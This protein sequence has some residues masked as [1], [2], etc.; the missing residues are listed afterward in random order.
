MR[1]VSTSG[2]GSQS[3]YLF[4]G[5]LNTGKYSVKQFGGAMKHT[6]PN[7]VM[8]PPYGADFVILPTQGFG[9][10]E[11][12]KAALVQ[13]KPDVL[14]L[15]TDPRFFIWVW[16]MEEEIHQICPIVYWH[17]WDNDPYPDFNEVLYKST[18]LLNCISYKTFELVKPHFPEKTNYIPHSLP[19]ELF[20]PL[21]KQDVLNAKQNFLGLNKV[22]HFITTWIGRNAIRKNPG[23][24][25]IAWKEFLDSLEAK[26]GHRKATLIMH[27]DAPSPE[28]EGPNLVK[29]ADSLGILP[30]VVFSV[31]KIEFEHMNL[32][33]NISD[34]NINVSCL[35]AGELIA[36][37]KG[38]KPIET[39]EVGDVVTTHKNRQRKVLKTFKNPLVN[40]KVFEVKSSNNTPLKITGNHK[41]RA[42]QKNITRQ[43][44]KKF[45]MNEQI[46]N[47]ERF[48]SWVPVEEL[49]VGD[50]VVYDIP[51][52]KQTA[53]QLLI[54][55]KKFANFKEKDWHK[56]IVTDSQIEREGYVSN[57]FV[58]VN[59]NFAYIL[60]AWMGNGSTNSC[61]VTF[62][63]NH[64]KKHQKYID[65][66]KSVFPHHTVNIESE[67][68][69]NQV[70]L[71]INGYGS[72]TT[73]VNMFHECCGMYSHN[74]HIPSF[75]LGANK[76]IKQ[77][78]L[79]GYQAADG[80]R[81]NVTKGM[82]G[83][84][85]RFRTVSHAI[86]NDLRD[87]LASLGHCVSMNY[88]TN[89]GSLKLGQKNKI[90]TIQYI[91][92]KNK[93]NKIGNGSC[94][95]WNVNNKF[96][97]SRV[98][99]INELENT[100]GQYDFVYNF[101]VEEDN[102][103]NT[104]SF[105]VKNCAEGFGVPTC[106]AMFAGKPIIGLTTGGQTRQLINWKTG[107]ENG[108]AMKPDARRCIGTLMCPYIY[109][110][111]VNTS[112]I[113]NAIM[114]MYDL[115]P[116]G[117]E[118]LGSKARAYALEE[119]SYKKMIEQWDNS[120]ENIIEKWKSDRESVYQPW[121]VKSL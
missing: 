60:G 104:A 96:I 31:E 58:N 119:F 10:P 28:N 39:I 8:V 93:G 57:R 72:T 118:A 81:I 37:S 113:A 84:T 112:T 115:G 34:I 103:Y 73:L 85:I 62:N 16:E 83:D 100:N 75:I 7:V 109:E 19:E 33:H 87:L 13:E 107:E 38:Y 48:I 76:E 24:L 98:Y 5:L 25:L 51:Q 21:P 95:T 9:T 22:D 108:V 99:E 3:R 18:D 35:P 111:F 97:V 40:R 61:K 65:C 86:A 79:D 56:T 41:V 47:L 11:L 43:H 67:T 54:D 6:N 30:N 32:I 26:H 102:S 71:T 49:K 91:E 20:R 88:E 45:F 101:E 42:I 78:F 117:R 1:N 89:K 14:F 68:E 59:E 27:T 80:C 63:I 114:K 23:H 110:D 2:V 90:W 64:T 105:T 44:K 94:R 53:N 29:V 15:F 77:A 50:Y 116:A 66:V 55:L 70:N 12:L 69:K 52:H 120:L 121:E 17:I 92:R 46:D 4:Q 36:T 106:E 74:K 82:S